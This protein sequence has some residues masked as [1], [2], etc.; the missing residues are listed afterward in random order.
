MKFTDRLI[1]AWNAFS[2]NDRKSY[3]QYP[4]NNPGGVTSSYR[5][6]KTPLRVGT[7]RS[8][9]A[10]IYNRIAIDVAAIEIRH[11]RIDA[12]RRFQG[13]IKSSLKSY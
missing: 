11:A 8:I 9:L 12:D 7:E 4:I 10:S 1:H 5:I 13:E 3:N 6:D 2:L